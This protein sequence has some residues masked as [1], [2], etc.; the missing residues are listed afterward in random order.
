MLEERKDLVSVGGGEH[1]VS[2]VFQGVL[3]HIQKVL[4]IVDDQKGCRHIDS[5]RLQNS[6]FR[7]SQRR[8]HLAPPSNRMK[9]VSDAAHTPLRVSR[10]IV[11]EAITSGGTSMPGRYVK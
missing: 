11:P 3:N 4:F 10:R 2:F 7:P 9:K 5:S 1:P 8:N 6:P